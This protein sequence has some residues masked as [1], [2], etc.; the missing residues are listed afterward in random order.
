MCVGVSTLTLKV[1][2]ERRTTRPSFALCV[3]LISAAS[4]EPLPRGSRAVAFPRWLH[5]LSYSCSTW[6]RGSSFVVASALV[7]WLHWR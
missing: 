5:I 6:A 2:R 7:F 3:L 4:V 1:S